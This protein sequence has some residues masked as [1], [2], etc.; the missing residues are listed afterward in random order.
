VLSNEVRKYGY[1]LGKKLIADIIQN[2]E[3]GLYVLVMPSGAKYWRLKYRFAGP[4][5]SM[6]KTGS[7]YYEKLA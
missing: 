7:I 6:Y 3:K 4:A 2:D 5:G 1:P